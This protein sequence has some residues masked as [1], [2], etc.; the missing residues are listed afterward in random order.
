[1]KAQDV[2]NCFSKAGLF[3]G[4]R[5]AR[6]L[7]SL[8]RGRDRKRGREGSFLFSFFQI[9]RI[10]SR[11]VRVFFPRKLETR[12]QNLYTR[13]KTPE[14]NLLN[15]SSGVH[16]IKVEGEIL[17]GVNLQDTPA[18]TKRTSAK[19]DSADRLTEPLQKVLEMNSFILFAG[20][21]PTPYFVW[22]ASP[23]SFL[24]GDAHG[25]LLVRGGGFFFSFSF[26]RANREGAW[27]D[28]SVIESAYRG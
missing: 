27:W 7:F 16:I 9:E 15:F 13:G 26:A 18:R 1:M 14:K 8:A 19:W 21:D 25:S 11:M 22:Q 10:E 4:R 28:C 5:S 2:A 23:A 24:A 3:F 6:A 20:P 12:S 17:L